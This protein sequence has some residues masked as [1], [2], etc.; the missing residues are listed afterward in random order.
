V[1]FLILKSAPL[2]LYLEKNN[3][4][5]F[6]GKIIHGKMIKHGFLRRCRRN[7]NELNYFAPN[8]FASSCLAKKIPLS[9]KSEKGDFNSA[10][11]LQAGERVLVMG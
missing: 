2:I 3:K 10:S 7:L 11:P 5:I 6:F 4:P 9:G 8:Y 1:L